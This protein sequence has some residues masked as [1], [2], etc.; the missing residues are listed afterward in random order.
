MIWIALAIVVA[1]LVI[2]RGIGQLTTAVT[3]LRLLHEH[4]AIQRELDLSEYR[5]DILT[6]ASGIPNA[7]DL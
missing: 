5:D 7:R 3:A 1:A 6:K 2:A 4:I